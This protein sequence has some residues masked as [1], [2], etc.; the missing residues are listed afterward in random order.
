MKIKYIRLSTQQYNIT[1]NASVAFINKNS[2][3]I[4][5]GLCS[6]TKAV[7]NWNIPASPCIDKSY[8]KTSFNLVR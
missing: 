2:S 3:K 4:D 1:L 7:R 6:R 8:V 5:G